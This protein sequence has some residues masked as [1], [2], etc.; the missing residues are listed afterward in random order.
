[1][2]HVFDGTTSDRAGAWL[3]VDLDA[4]TRNYLFLSKKVGPAECAAV[5][6]ADAYGLGL[7]HV[8]PVLERAG[9]RTFFVAHMEEGVALRKILPNVR[10]FVL[11]GFMPGCAE[12]MLTNNLL[13]VLNDVSQVR[14]WKTL[15]V[16]IGH[17]LPAA[18]QFDSGMSRFGLSE[19]DLDIPGLL[20]ETLKPV[21]VMSHLACA[22]MPDSIFSATQ[23]ERFLQMAS[24]F[25]GVPRS[26]SASSG[27]FLGPDYHFELVRPGA[28]LY[29]IAPD[30]GPN[31]LSAVISLDARVVQ[32]RS[33]KAGDRVGYGL[34]WTA[35]EPTRLATLGIGYA[36]GF[37][38]AQ[39]GQAAVWYQDVR[40]PLVGRVSM[41]SISIDISALPD[42]TL[43]PG[44]ILSVVGPKQ[45]VDALARTGGTIG[46][47][48]LTSLGSRFHRVYKMEKVLAESI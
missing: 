14:A 29:G 7:T 10:I 22:D 16:K 31:P 34:T 19:A 18:I 32:V 13:P 45:D 12:E 40:L 38:R 39:A 8:G 25:P 36:D 6:K 42:S 30:G 37:F 28:A 2:Q 41:D 20:D 15:S 26:L 48:I 5:V 46:Y 27:I 43:K 9:A 47:E 3:S 23:R 33:I 35:K 1:M 17:A 11:H 24:R 44:D 4:L 21:L